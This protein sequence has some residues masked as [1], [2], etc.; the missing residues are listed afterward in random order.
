MDMIFLILTI[1]LFVGMG[2]LFSFGKGSFLIAGF[3]TLPKIEKDK[4]DI[5]ALT[6]F[7][8][9]LMFAIAFSILLSFLG[10]KLNIKYLYILGQIIV[11][12]SIVFALIYANT[13]NRF[14]K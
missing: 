5:I 1:F 7:M 13:N 8:G 14:K 4:Y 10:E 6:K 2:I 12:G 11:F 9:K 3:N